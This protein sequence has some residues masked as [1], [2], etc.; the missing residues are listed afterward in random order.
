M[1]ARTDPTSCAPLRS[2]KMPLG[3]GYAVSF[4]FEA[5]KLDCEWYPRLPSPRK[6]RGLLPAYRRARDEFI[7]RIAARTGLA[8]LVVDL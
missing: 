8:V 5:N 4:V 1:T 6:G 3:R 2:E 7:G